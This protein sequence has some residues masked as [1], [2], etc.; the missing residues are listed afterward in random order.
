MADDAKTLQQRR[1]ELVRR[2]VAES[3][4]AA[5]E[6]AKRAHIRAGERYRLS[7]G[8][9]R[10]WFLQTMDAGDVTLNVCVSYRLTGGPPSS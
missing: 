3:G 4:L 7:T 1:R 8:Q 5:A 10:M 9:R 2:R 6:S